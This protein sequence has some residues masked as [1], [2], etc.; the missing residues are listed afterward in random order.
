MTGFLSVFWQKC[1]KRVDLPVPALPV[2]KRLRSVFS[3]NAMAVSNC[4][5]IST[6]TIGLV[7]AQESNQFPL[8]LNARGGQV[9]RFVV[10]V[11]GF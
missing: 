7:M 9:A 1:D 5:L 8:D 6:C 2:I 3:I 10:F 4:A 11:G